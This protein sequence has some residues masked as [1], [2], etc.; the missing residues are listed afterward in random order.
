MDPKAMTK[1]FQDVSLASLALLSL[2]AKAQVDTHTLARFKQRGLYCEIQDVDFQS[3]SKSGKHKFRRKKLTVPLPTLT[4]RDHFYLQVPESL[5]PYIAY[6]GFAYRNLKALHRDR[7]RY[8]EYA[9]YLNK[10][11]DLNLRTGAGVFEV[12]AL[13]GG[14]LL[15]DQTRTKQRVRLAGCRLL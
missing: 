12:E 11:L 7:L 9:S 5:V 3:K 13:S 4:E 14:W 2:S 6:R 10:T 1:F 15:G 8:T